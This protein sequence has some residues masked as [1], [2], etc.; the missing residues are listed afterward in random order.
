MIGIGIDASTTCIGYGV[1]N[2]NKL[3]A[4]GKI[5]PSEEC[6]TWRDRVQDYIPKL[7]ELIDKYKPT[8]VCIE[9]VPLIKKKM[10]TLVM[11]GSVQGMLLGVFGRNG[12]DIEFRSVSSWRSDIGLFDGTKEGKER[13]NMKIKSIQRAN[14]LFGLDLACVFTRNGKYNES[15]SDDDISD[16][17]LVYASTLD[18]YKVKKKTFGRR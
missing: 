7:Q 15:K 13:D 12:I 14:E 8:K 4:Y 6:V 5:K 11:L 17:I 1:F 2:N 10:M 9:D 16:G 3:I 18:K